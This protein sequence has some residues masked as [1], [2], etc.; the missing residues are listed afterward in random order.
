LQS[1]HQGKLEWTHLLGTC[2]AGPTGADCDHRPESVLLIIGL[3]LFYLWGGNLGRA[4]GL[5]VILFGV[6]GLMV[7]PTWENNARAYYAEIVKASETG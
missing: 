5:V 1:L 7:D 4:T 3:A 6:A 2:A